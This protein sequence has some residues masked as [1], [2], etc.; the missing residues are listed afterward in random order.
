MS[1]ASGS[2]SPRQRR[3]LSGHAE[4]ITPILDHLED[5]LFIIDSL[6]RVVF[7]NTAAQR[8]ADSGH[9][10]RVRAG[11]L[12][13]ATLSETS[14]LDA[15]LAEYIGSPERR[16]CRGLRLTS[17]TGK[18]WLLLCTRIGAPD[19]M[20]SFCIHL[21]RR[22]GVRRLPS[23]ALQELFSLSPRELVVLEK[24]AAGADLWQIAADIHLS[25]ESVR[26]Y[27]KR[28]FRKC[29]VHSQ[30]ELITLVQRLSVFAA[31]EP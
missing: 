9:G 16:P 18:N 10:A 1:T 2:V 23:T 21:V 3:L 30:E 22:I 13:M 26:V 15:L 5:P 31:K 4:A 29:E 8:T 7:R 24:L 11:R 28:V 14:A 12:V 27:L 17:S 6:R 25:R 20:G 19:A